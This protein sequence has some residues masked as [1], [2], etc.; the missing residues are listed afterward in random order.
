[1]PLKRSSLVPWGCV[2]QLWLRIL[3]VFFHATYRQ[4]GIRF[5]NIQISDIQCTYMYIFTYVFTRIRTKNAW[6]RMLFQ[7]IGSKKFNTPLTHHWKYYPLFW[8]HQEVAAARVKI[9]YYKTILFRQIFIITRILIDIHIVE[10]F[11]LIVCR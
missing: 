3:D 11:F 9:Y 1:M 4:N 5:S 10:H 6:L 7:I 2:T 8:K